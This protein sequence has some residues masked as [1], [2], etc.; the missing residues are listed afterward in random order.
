MTKYR[1]EFTRIGRTHEP[2]FLEVEATSLDDVVQAVYSH[3]RR[4]LRSQDYDV[5]LNGQSMQGVI[6]AGLHDAGRFKVTEA[7]T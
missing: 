5:E 2:P 1:I 3:A 6:Y 4:F 7:P